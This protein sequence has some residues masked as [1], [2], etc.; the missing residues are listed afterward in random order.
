MR[1]WPEKAW[2]GVAEETPVVKSVEWVKPL[3]ALELNRFFGDEVAA[4]PGMREVERSSPA[5][6]VWTR[7]HFWSN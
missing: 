1:L 3:T 7:Q 6:V 5:R 4:W 2:H